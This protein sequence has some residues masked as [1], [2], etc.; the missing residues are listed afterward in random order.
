[1]DKT[2][3]TFKNKRADFVA[4]TLEVKGDNLVVTHFDPKGNLLTAK[5]PNPNTLSARFKEALLLTY[6]QI[7]KE[8]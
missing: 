6:K 4:V 5:R 7:Y 2:H 1:M 3:Y 8:A